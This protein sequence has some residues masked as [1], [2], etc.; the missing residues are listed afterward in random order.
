MEGLF[1][2]MGIRLISV[3]MLLFWVFKAPG[4]DGFK[5]QIPLFFEASNASSFE[6]LLVIVGLLVAGCVITVRES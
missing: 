4:W 2:N 6:L 3:A 1:R 5:F